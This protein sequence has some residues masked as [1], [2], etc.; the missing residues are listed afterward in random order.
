MRTKVFFMMLAVAVALT[1]SACS[2]HYPQGPDGRVTDRSDAYYKSG[3]WQ[4]HL[5]VAPAAGGEPKKFRVTKNDYKSCFR[6]SR[7]PACTERRSA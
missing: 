5:T 3:G 7:Y 1:L 2:P 6:G 4:Y